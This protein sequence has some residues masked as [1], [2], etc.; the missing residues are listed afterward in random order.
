MGW[1]EESLMPW[2]Y[3]HETTSDIV[4]AAY[5]GEVSALDLRE[6]TTTF[7]RL[8]KEQGLVKFLIDTSEMLLATSMIDLYEL[9]TKQYIEEGADRQGRV[10][11]I[12]PASK[13][14]V[15]AVRFYESVCQN[16]GWHVRVFEQ[17]A[18]AL[19]WLKDD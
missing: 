12:P 6:S 9:P 5:T 7:I 17:R 16:R 13:S 8:E 10:A 11:I 2:S 4:E 14:A 18:E 15:E 3:Q 1:N 19:K